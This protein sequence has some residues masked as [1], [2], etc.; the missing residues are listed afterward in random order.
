MYA[1]GARTRR[2]EAQSGQQDPVSAVLGYYNVTPLTKGTFSVAEGY[3]ETVIP[4][5]KDMAIAK[6]F[7]LDLAGRITGYS[8][9]GITETWKVGV[10]YTPFDDQIR[11]R[12][13][14]S[15][16]IRAPNLTELFQPRTL[17]LQTVLDPVTNQQTVATTINGGNPNLVPEQANNLTA[18]FV[19]APDWLP[20]F[21]A[22]FD[23]FGLSVHGAISTLT[24]Q[25]VVNN[26][27]QANQAAYCAL[28]TRN[29]GA[30]GINTVTVQK[31]NFQTLYTDGVDMEASYSF[32]GA[33]VS[34]AVPGSFT[35]RFL[36]NYIEHLQIAAGGVP[37]LE[38]A[39]QDG[40]VGTATQGMPHFRGNFV[41]TWI[42]DPIS[43]QANVRYI[44]GGTLNN[45]YKFGVD[46]SP[47][48]GHVTNRT[49]LDLSGT[50][51]FMPG[52]QLFG[53][54]ANVFDSAP[55]LTPTNILK[56]LASGS[57]LFD[58]LGQTYSLG[59]RLRY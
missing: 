15:H 33:D 50:Y 25:Q 22:S 17:G 43:I 39:G 1:P 24:P 7:N 59:I 4:L 3:V 10:N 18:G 49:Y 6:S 28:I 37:T 35:L 38:Y 23:Y 53:K 32:D 5:A 12:G 51:D 55:P 56:P 40:S 21:Q 44:Q 13:T 20:G 34:S 30:G 58:Q 11:I 31:F 57:P 2:R 27:Y 46:I 16:D 36:G 47:Q 9:S 8:N 52:I 42:F 41:A 19:Y 14:W 45:A 54:I 29:S 26:C 48:D